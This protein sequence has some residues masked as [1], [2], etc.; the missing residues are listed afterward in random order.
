MAFK[1]LPRLLSLQIIYPS[2]KVRITNQIKR[3]CG[4]FF[5]LLS[6]IDKLFSFPIKVMEDVKALERRVKKMGGKS[7][8]EGEK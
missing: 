7:K 4:V 5:F 1:I 8:R 2:H 3:G 6:A